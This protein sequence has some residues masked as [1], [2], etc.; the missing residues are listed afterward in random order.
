[1]KLT[2]ALA[3]LTCAGALCVRAQALAQAPLPPATVKVQLLGLNDFHGQ[4]DAGKKLDERPVGGAAVLASY[5]RDATARFAGDTL[6]VHAGDW[7]GASPPSSGLLQDEP[8]IGVLNLLANRSCTRQN[9]MHPRCNIVGTPGNHEF[10]EGVDELSRLIRGGNAKRGPFLDDPYRGARFPYVTAT[11]VDKKTGRTLFPPYVV[12]QLSG[13]KVGVIGA[14]LAETPSMV[15]AEGVLK[16]DFL[17]EAEA[18]NLHVQQLKKQGVQTIVVTIHQGGPQAPYEGPTRAEVAG[19]SEGIPP[20]IAE[21][22]DAVDVVVSGH[23]H[24]FTNALMKN[25]NGHPILVTQAWSAG[26][27]FAAI[28]LTIDRKTRDVVTKTA[29]IVP[30]YSD[31]GP[32]LTPAADVA[33]LVQR[34]DE[35]VAPLSAHPVG[36]CGVALPQ[37]PNEAGESALGNLIADAQRSVTGAQIALMNQGGI[38]ASLE[39]GP[40]TW[41]ELFAIQPFANA[42]VTMDLTGAEVQLALEQQWL[43]PQVHTLQVSGLTYTWDPKRASGQ[44]V[45]EV[46]VGGKPLVGSAVYRVAVNSFLAGGGGGFSVFLSGRD[47]R[48]GPIDLDVLVSHIEVTGRPVDARI[49]GRI[50]LATQAPPQPRSGASGGGR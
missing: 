25:K 7:V 49:E 14:V 46:L 4:L 28:E 1:M 21:L 37:K 2:T 41:G 35:R 13:I 22:D 15:V 11:V 44:R 50:Q 20:I 31:A 36:K 6:I 30:T 8:S 33:A 18:I 16:V 39:P 12:K 42:V 43:S 9:R 19:P 27:A 47:Q 26:S 48:T 10:D 29:R 45:V 24:S 3:A 17:P 40:I 32:G 34:A 23:A 38:R 5:L